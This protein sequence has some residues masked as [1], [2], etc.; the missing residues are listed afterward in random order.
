MGELRVL[1]EFRGYQPRGKR[2]ALTAP[3]VA[4][5]LADTG[6]VYHYCPG[7]VELCPNLG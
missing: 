6:A 4:E 7:L 5:G 3:V 1:V 2:L